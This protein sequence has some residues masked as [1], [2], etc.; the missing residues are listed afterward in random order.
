MA[1]VFP[2]DK[3]SWIMSRVRSRDTRPERTV[4]SLVHRMGYR[5][6]LHGRDLPGHPDI[7]LPRHKKAILVHGCFWHGHEQCPRSKR[8]ATNAAFWAKKLD[9]NIAR[10][11]AYLDELR[12]LG[13]GVLVVWECETR[14][15]RPCC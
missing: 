13:W 10:D 8:P 12:R 1:D 3:R 11:S 7:V 14:T 6:R 5:F 2:Q 15:R 4:R 9:G